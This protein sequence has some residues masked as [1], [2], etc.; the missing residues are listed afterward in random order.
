[1]SQAEGK[2]L[3]SVGIKVKEGSYVDLI[4]KEGFFEKSNRATYIILKIVKEGMSVAVNLDKQKASRLSLLLN[5]L[6]MDGTD[7]DLERLKKKYP[8]QKTYHIL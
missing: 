3:K 8:N 4:L 6:V 2:E 1:M 5:Q 7:R